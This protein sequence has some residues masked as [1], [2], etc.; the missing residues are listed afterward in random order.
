TGAKLAEYACEKMN[1]QKVVIF[2]NLNSHY[3]NSIREEFTKKFEKLLTSNKKLPCEVVSG[4]LI[5]LTATGFDAEKEVARSV[6]TH[7]AEGALLV[8]NT[9]KVDIAV[10]I[11][12]EITKRN[13]KLKI[14][15]TRPEVKML[16]GDTLY[17]HDITIVRGGKNVEGLIIAIPW[18]RGTPAAQKFAKE[19]QQLWGGDVSWR[20]ATSF[21]ATQAFIKSLSN[22]ASRKTVLGNLKNVNL[23]TDETSGYPLEFTEE[24]ERQG[25]SILLQVKDGKL[26]EIK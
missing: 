23:A 14:R 18:F 26:I 11:A 17:N 16:A 15:N 7:K 4:P 19:L 8:P 25:E 21:D 6:Y 24:R 5:D 20:T 22:G 2:A 9:D 10:N 13:E 3:S 1:L 12:R